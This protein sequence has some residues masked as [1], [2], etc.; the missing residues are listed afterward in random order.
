MVNRI[1]YLLALCLVMLSGVSFSVQ[2]GREDRDRLIRVETTLR[3]FMDQIDKR[4]EQVDKRFESLDKRFE[5]IDKRFEQIDK[6]FEQL[7]K[8]FEQIDK[9]FEQINNELDRLVTIIAAVFGG[10]LALVAAVF[11]FAYWDRRTIVHKAR[12]DT[13]KYLEEEGKVRTIIQVLRD[14]A[15]TDK[16]LAEILRSHGML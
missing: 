15:K 8:R 2:F 4:F 12:D 6:R 7:D 1:P 3:V 16:E 9:R 11:G 13:V 14:K 10:Q 5:Q